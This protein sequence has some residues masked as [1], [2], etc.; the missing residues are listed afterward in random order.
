MMRT[1]IDFWRD[2]AAACALEYALIASLIAVIALSMI[3][4]S[5][6]QM[7]GAVSA[8]AAG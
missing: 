1:L 6:A 2:K 7:N 4:R 3:A 5:G 8:V